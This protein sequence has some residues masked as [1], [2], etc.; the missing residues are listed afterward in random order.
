MSLLVLTSG[1][2]F[3]YFVCRTFVN[4]LPPKY[5]LDFGN[6]RWIE[7]REM[8]PHV[9]F[10]KE[11]FLPDAVRQA[12]IQVAATDLFELSINGRT[13][14]QEEFVSTRVA[15]LYDL[16]THL[17]PGKNVIG[18][19]VERK[20]YPGSSQLCVR[21]TVKG[22]GG[23]WTE[24][25]SDETWKAASD[26]AT[27]PAGTAWNSPLL[28]DTAWATAK[29]SDVGRDSLI[30]QVDF[31]P[32]LLE[33]APEGEWIAA[34]AANDRQ[35]SFFTRIDLPRGSQETWLQVAATGAYDLVIN[36][37]PVAT[38]SIPDQAGIIQRTIGANTVIPALQAFYITPWLR[39]GSNEILI[40]VR[41]ERSAV[42]LLADGF[43][44]GPGGSIQRIKTDA[45]WN[46]MEK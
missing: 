17:Q 6:A 13:L 8:S 23:N 43:T 7:P 18:V 32:R 3:G 11:V 34:P 33:L 36:G 26:T 37:D 38:E 2:I 39:K 40:R 15:G 19:R 29:L 21:A 4:P 30:Q 42:A 24:I 31:N 1:L 35:R 27:V 5:T 25:L 16:K 45:T 44:I 22:A 9:F 12:W 14:P 10:R 46:T 28:G 20:S 41:P